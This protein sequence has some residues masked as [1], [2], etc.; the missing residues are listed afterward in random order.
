VIGKNVGNYAVGAVTY[1]KDELFN[2]QSSSYGVAQDYFIPRKDEDSIW[3]EWNNVNTDK[4]EMILNHC[5]I[6]FLNTSSAGYT[7][8]VTINAGFIS[9]YPTE[10]LWRED[11]KRNAETGI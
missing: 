3:F 7:I 5:S 8:E 4:S 2:T 11:G 6:I 9:V 1:P 10:C